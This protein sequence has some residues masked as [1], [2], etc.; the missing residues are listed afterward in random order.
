MAL[1]LAPGEYMAL[2]C[3]LA[4]ETLE[5]IYYNS[6]FG[7]KENKLKTVFGRSGSFEPGLN[8]NWFYH[9]DLLAVIAFRMSNFP[10]A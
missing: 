5:I 10:K 9:H 1:N 2:L 7:Q 8:L 3:S 4:S 6:L